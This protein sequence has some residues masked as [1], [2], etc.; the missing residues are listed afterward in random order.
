MDFGLF[1]LVFP[2]S[3][4]LVYFEMN[5]RSEFSRQ[6]LL[7][8]PSS[9]PESCLRKIPFVCGS[10]SRSDGCTKRVGV[11]EKG[12]CTRVAGDDRRTGQN[13]AASLPP[14]PAAPS[15]APF[16]PSTLSPHSYRRSTLIFSLSKMLRIHREGV[17]LPDQLTRTGCCRRRHAHP[18]PPLSM[19]SS[20]W[21]R[22]SSLTTGQRRDA[23]EPSALV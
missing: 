20:L 16:V 6:S 9:L 15:A 1:D 14:L 5:S 23:R 18:P 12:K 8:A 13:S 11:G 2:V 7:Q 10:W 22:Q 19:C 17:R 4:V 3:S 21:G